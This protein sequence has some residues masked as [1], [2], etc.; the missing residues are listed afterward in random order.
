MAVALIQPLA[1]ELP[2]AMGTA[3]KKEKKFLVVTQQLTNP[4]CVH[5]DAGA[6]PGFAQGLKDP[7]LP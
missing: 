7:P 5:V 1:W 4:T 6:I 3:F 2:Y